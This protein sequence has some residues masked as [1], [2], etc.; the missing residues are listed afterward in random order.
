[1]K[2]FL[3]LLLIGLLAAGAEAQ[4]RRDRTSPRNGSA[5]DR[6]PDRTSSGRPSGPTS[7]SPVIDNNGDLTTFD[8]YRVLSEHNIFMKNRARPA[9]R[10]S[11]D[12]PRDPPRR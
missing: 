5:S 12:R 1:M 4:N 11:N 10:P 6:P 8:R 3:P 2:Y 7:A 9:T